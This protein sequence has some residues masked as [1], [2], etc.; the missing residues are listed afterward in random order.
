MTFRPSIH[1]SFYHTVYVKCL[2]CTICQ[3]ESTLK[4]WSDWKTK[5]ATGFINNTTPKAQTQK[6]LKMCVSVHVTSAGS[7]M[8]V[9]WLCLSLNNHFFD[10]SVSTLPQDMRNNRSFHQHCRG[11]YSCL[12]FFLRPVLSFTLQAVIYPRGVDWDVAVRLRWSVVYSPL[13][14]THFFLNLLCFSWE[15][16]D[17]FSNLRISQFIRST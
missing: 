16:A 4:T 12:H 3:V 14:F 2:I 10:Y 7:Q 17:L 15:W 5:S 1:P 6:T 11:I 8:W 13:C 9:L